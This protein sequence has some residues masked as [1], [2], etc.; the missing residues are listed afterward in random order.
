MCGSLCSWGKVCMPQSWLM[1]GKGS[2][3]GKYVCGI[4]VVDCWTGLCS[5]EKAS[6][7]EVWLMIIV[8][9]VVEGRCVWLR[10]GS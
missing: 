1:F 3:L 9:F 6:V 2:G 5:F 4:L 10:A 7:A 8:V